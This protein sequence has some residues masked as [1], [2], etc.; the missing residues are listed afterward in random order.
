MM[1]AHVKRTYQIVKQLCLTVAVAAFV[2]LDMLSA[3]TGGV[4]ARFWTLGQNQGQ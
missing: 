4:I 2:A 1:T 3:E